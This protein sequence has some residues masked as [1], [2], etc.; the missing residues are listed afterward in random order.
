MKTKQRVISRYKPR[1]IDKCRYKPGGGH[2]FLD[3]GA[4]IECYSGTSDVEAQ[5]CFAEAV[6]AGCVVVERQEALPIIDGVEPW[7][8]VSTYTRPARCATCGGK[9][10]ILCD[11]Y[12]RDH[13]VMRCP[14]CNAG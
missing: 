4:D 9:R 10:F 6:R 3:D 5:A 2:F 1:S 8:T 11:N 12:E 13:E 7:G 14:D